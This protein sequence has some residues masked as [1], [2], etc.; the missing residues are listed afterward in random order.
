MNDDLVSQLL[1]EK[2]ARE[3]G[4]DPDARSAYEPLRVPERSAPRS[5]NVPPYPTPAPAP[6]VPPLPAPMAAPLS[7]RREAAG[8]E[9]PALPAPPMAA[10]PPPTGALPPITAAAP[11]AFAPPPFSAAPS[12]SRREAAGAEAPALPPPPRRAYEAPRT[13]NG[14]PTAAE[15]ALKTLI[16]FGAAGSNSLTAAAP[17]LMRLVKTVDWV[18]VLQSVEEGM[19]A[20]Q[21]RAIYR[22]VAITWEE[23]GVCSEFVVQLLKDA[24]KLDRDVLDKVVELF[25][26]EKPT[27][28]F[29][30]ERKSE[31]CRELFPRL[32]QIQAVLGRARRHADD[33]VNGEAQKDL[34]QLAT[35]LKSVRTYFNS[36]NGV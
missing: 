14:Q 13:T 5:S 33:G 1:R 3:Q 7:S 36:L 28:Y 29:S 30:P 32:A 2:R 8:T 12:P 23:F 18:K 6:G 22:A 11:P 26:G 25:K 4:A 31:V 27:W 24:D 34:E 21:E 20:K 19:R 9:V 35:L 17:I 16:E 10:A 15:E